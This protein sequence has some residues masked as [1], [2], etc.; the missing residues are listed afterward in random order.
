MIWSSDH[1]FL[2]F[3]DFFPISIGHSLLKKNE[4]TNPVYAE[5][6]I[7]GSY[8][9]VLHPSIRKVPARS[10]HLKLKSGSVLSF[11]SRCLIVLGEKKKEVTTFHRHEKILFFTSSKARRSKIRWDF[12]FFPALLHSLSLSSYIWIYLRAEIVPRDD[13]GA[14][15]SFTPQKKCTQLRIWGSDCL[16]I[17][18]TRFFRD[19]PLVSNKKSP[20]PFFSP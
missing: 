18:S 10:A 14:H 7:W 15:K 16:T 20:D 9:H 6:H 4:C 8:C 3:G 1:I 17:A 2:F 13:F 12:S 5:F 11:F 19:H